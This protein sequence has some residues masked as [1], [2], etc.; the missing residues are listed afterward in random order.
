MKPNWITILV[1]G[2]LM[3]WLLAQF[4]VETP[5][6]SS[7]EGYLVPHKPQDKHGKDSRKDEINELRMVIEDLKKRLSKPLQNNEN[8]DKRSIREPEKENDK[9]ENPI[10]R[11]EKDFAH[12]Q[13]KRPSVASTSLKQIKL[14]EIERLKGFNEGVPKVVDNKKRNKQSKGRQNL[15]SNDK[16][17]EET[18][19]K[20]ILGWPALHMA[21]YKKQLKIVQ[22]L[23][24]ENINI[25]RKDSE[26]RSA[27]HIAALV[28]SK[29]IT[30]LLIDA[31]CKTAVVDL[32]GQYFFH[33]AASFGHDYFKFLDKY[34]IGLQ[35]KDKSGRNVLHLAAIH[36]N[37]KGLHTLM[38]LN[39][40]FDETDVN[41]ATPL[42][43]AV[44]YNSMAAT[45]F[46]V[47]HGAKVHAKDSI[48]R[49]PLHYSV[50]FNKKSL[51]R[52]LIKLGA[53][54]NEI[55]HMGKT[56]L[57]YAASAGSYSI[58]RLLGFHGAVVIA[59]DYD[60][61]TPLHMAVQIGH[62]RVVRELLD[63]GAYV[64]VRDR[65][66]RTLL[67]TAVQNGYTRLVKFLLNRGAD[68]RIDDNEGLLPSDWAKSLK[69]QKAYQLLIEYE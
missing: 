3:G 49:T 33:L 61:Q 38:N 34:R 43:L 37:V 40:P 68:A 8:L 69:N 65:L 22:K 60:S 46:L 20:P 47:D 27:L 39:F 12:E 41:G 4:L 63:Q 67:H 17:N 7:D 64:N 14:D 36:N 16:N 56:A 59:K 19:V 54:T 51:L 42:H 13:E 50:E 35:T 5:A 26:G 6:K 52:Y 25:D 11:D 24:E 55:D 9:N 30:G 58:V 48:G 31:G 10:L 28:D 66:G 29:V 2:F 18:K 57:H 44:R 15:S 23:L 32:Q 21:V 45:K 1:F 53:D 62:E